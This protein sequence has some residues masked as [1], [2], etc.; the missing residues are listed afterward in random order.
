[1]GFIPLIIDSAVKYAGPDGA[2][3]SALLLP[4]GSRSILEHAL[5]RAKQLEPRMLVVLQAAGTEPGAPAG[6]DPAVPVR[7]VG[8]DQLDEIVG[9]ADGSDYFLVLDTRSWPVM[10]PSAAEL[11]AAVSEYHGAT[12]AIAIGSRPERAVERIECGAD[13][14]VRRVLRLY[15]TANWSQTTGH[16]VAYSLVPTQTLGGLRFHSL[17][18]LRQE[19]AVRGV[20]GRDKPTSRDV[21]DLMRAGCYL[22]LNERVLVGGGLDPCSNRDRAP[23]TRIV[24]SRKARVDPSARLIPPVVVR[25][26]AVIGPNALVVGPAVIGPNGCV[27]DRAVVAQSV[28][29]P[30]AVV[31]PGMVIRQSVYADRSTAPTRP[32]RSESEVQCEPVSALSVPV[33]EPGG[34]GGKRQYRRFHSVAKRLLDVLVSGSALVVLSPV[35]LIIALLVR[36]D[37]RGPVLFGHIRE[38]RGGKEF[39]CLKFRTMVPDADRRQKELLEKNLVDGPQVKIQNDPRVTRVGHWLRATNLDELP[40]LINVFLG[41]MSLVGPRPSP[42]RENQICVPW[43]HAR[44]SVPPGITG[45]WQICRAADR[46]R[47]DFHEWIFYDMTYI[48]HFSFW[49]DLKILLATFLTLGGHWHVPLPWMVRDLDGHGRDHSRRRPTAA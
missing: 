9:D 27:R 46:S 19:L 18:N 24:T 4:L 49:L 29:L 26:G 12:Y 47:G 41:H 10:L 16:A 32:P 35:L 43:R 45:L 17:D 2:G 48:K 21:L 7:F 30:G 37:T 15:A 22:S 44:L 33:I 34:A 8:F 38:R 1:M 39:K 28:V 14:Q 23:A 20:L 13:G 25:E 3:T 40:Q 5:E 11:H 36:I 6:L 31:P 42:F